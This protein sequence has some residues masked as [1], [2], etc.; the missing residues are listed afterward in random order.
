MMRISAFPKCWLED[1][2]SGK[3]SLH[4]WI[5]CSRRLGC[6]GL[7][8]YMGFL[9]SHDPAYLDE[10]RSHVES[11][12]M[13]VS[14]MCASPDFTQPDKA[15]REREIEKQIEAIRVTARL[16]GGFVRVLSGQKRPEI[17][18]EDGI[19]MVVQCIRRCIPAASEHGVVL[20]MENHYKDGY[21]KYSEFAQRMEIFLAI[22]N[23][24]DSPFFGV[25]YDPSNTLLANEDPLLLLDLVADRVKTMHASDRYV[26]K[27]HDVREVLESAASVG[28]HP[29]LRHGVVGRGLNDYEQIFRKLAAAKYDGWISIE[30]GMNGMEEMRESVDYLKEMRKKYFENR[31]V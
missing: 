8:L 3:M 29:A 22:V 30:D 31:S 6:E 7:E 12:G 10:I 11:L 21:W 26:E 15:A 27:G 17:G 24:I 18:V 20:S 14:M 1:I 9:Q 4:E 16:G 28:Y 19:D 23:R 2:C 25:Q 5:D 13:V